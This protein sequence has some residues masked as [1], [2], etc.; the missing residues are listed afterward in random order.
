MAGS[1][2]GKIGT[3]LCRIVVPAWVLT[4]AI[5]KL[6]S[7][8][9]ATLPQLFQDTAKGLGIA[10]DPLLYTLIALELFA[11]GVML[12]IGRFARL[13]AGFM[14]GS[15]CL[16]LIGEWIKQAES[17]G[18]FGGTIEIEPWQMLI[19]D[20]ALL[21]GVISLGTGRTKA[22]GQSLR[23]PAAVAFVLLLLGFGVSFAGKFLLHPPTEQEVIPDGGNDDPTRNPNPLPLPTSWYFD[24]IGNLV[25]KPWRELEIFKLM[26]RWPSDMDGERRYVVFYSRTCDHCEEMFLYD[27]TDPALGSMVT[28]IQIP[29]TPDTLMPDNAWEMPETECELLELPLGCDWILSAPATLRIE[30]GI[31]TCGTEGDHKQC[32]ELDE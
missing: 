19:I 8:T 6:L 12:S 29:H 21:L 16:I 7:G 2:R 28:A 27:L 11:I 10:M 3:V 25:G 32:M 20:G 15:F 23:T 13:M 14:L 4:G 5:F 24:D 18:C 17:C 22:K 31:V 26:P 30:N 9:P 1:V